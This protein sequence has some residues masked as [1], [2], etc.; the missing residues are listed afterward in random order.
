MHVLD[1]HPI[2]VPSMCIG[3]ASKSVHI[4]NRRS[5]LNRYMMG[6]AHI[7]SCAS[8]LS[9]H[10]CTTETEMEAIKL[11]VFF[12]VVS[13]WM[14]MRN[15]HNRG[16]EREWQELTRR[17]QDRKRQPINAMVSSSVQRAA[18]S[19]ALSTSMMHFD[20]VLQQCISMLSCYNEGVSITWLPHI[21][22]Q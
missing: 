19:L 14:L 3:C 4:R 21:H 15:R 10:G 17:S 20:R 22:Y 13:V 2:H 6:C 18:I 11:C 12:A 16:L 8:M 1:V 5:E 7:L 9:L